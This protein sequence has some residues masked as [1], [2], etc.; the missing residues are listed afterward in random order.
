MCNAHFVLVGFVRESAL[1]CVR[2]CDSEERVTVKAVLILL[3]QTAADRSDIASR[4]HFD[5]CRIELNQRI[6]YGPS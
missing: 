2:V 1:V 4:F 5:C 3:S 6:C